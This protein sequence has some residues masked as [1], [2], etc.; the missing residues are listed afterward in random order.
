MRGLRPLALACGLALAAPVA[1]AELPPLRQNDHVNSRL[2]AA[3]IGDQ[4]R[5]NCPTISPRRW[6]VRS[7]ALKLYNHARALGYDH[8][9]IEAYVRDPDARA[10]MERQRDA[11][12]AAN[13]VVAGNADSY[14]RVGLRE[15]GAGTY[16]GSLM[17]AD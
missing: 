2:L 5:R 17:R 1:G 6:H 3:A 13:G 8:A 16:L 12:L 10:W 7:E 9:T 4:I 15:I 11:W 14:C